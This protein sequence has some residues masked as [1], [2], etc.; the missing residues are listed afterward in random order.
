MSK[1]LALLIIILGVGILAVFIGFNLYRNYN[2]PSQV[3]LPSPLEHIEFPA[4]PTQ[5]PADWPDEFRLPDDFVLLDSTSG[6]LP[7]NTTKSWSAKLKYQ[8]K[9]FDALN[10][11]TEA[12]QEKGW[13]VIQSNRLDSGRAL[14]LLQR[15]GS[16]A[17]VVIDTD[18]NDS[19]VS[20]VIATYFP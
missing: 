19:S 18:P 8:G 5:Y 7:E 17:S 16:Q 12:L 14:L 2:R 13:V 3:S 1:K 9:P 6:T 4:E 20:L 11:M 10:V 15:G